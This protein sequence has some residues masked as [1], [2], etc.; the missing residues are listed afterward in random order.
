MC[1]CMCSSSTSCSALWSS[2]ACQGR[3]IAVPVSLRVAPASVLCCAVLCH[4]LVC[5]L[6]VS[7]ACWEAFGHRGSRCYDCISTCTMRGM[8][9]SVLVSSSCIY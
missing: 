6:R 1:M 4:P 5:A 7:S 9:F 2:V 3:C 8:I